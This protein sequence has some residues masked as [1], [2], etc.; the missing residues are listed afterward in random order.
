[1]R[2]RAVSSCAKLAVSCMR[3]MVLVSAVASSSDPEGENSEYFFACSGG[4]AGK[5]KM[6][7]EKDPSLAHAT[8]KNGEHCLHLTAISGSAEIAKLILDAGADPDV[9]STWDS[10]LRM[11]PLSWNTFYGRHD[12]IE[13][14]LKYGAD[15]NADFDL[16]ANAKKATVLDVIEQILLGTEDGEEKARFVKT[17]NI[18]V[19][20]GA[21][22][23]ASLEPEL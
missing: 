13:L 23:F 8:T 1:M 17:R 20:N 10:G 3:M 19:K 21:L 18:L 7:L 16:D 2:R 14:L 6:L 12:I 4:E 11:H 5:V 22:R 9:R 15:V